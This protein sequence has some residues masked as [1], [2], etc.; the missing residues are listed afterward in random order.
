MGTGP[1]GLFLV[2]SFDEVLHGGHGDW[3]PSFSREY[4]FSA[5]W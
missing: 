1:K 2:K 5:D 4:W 3:T